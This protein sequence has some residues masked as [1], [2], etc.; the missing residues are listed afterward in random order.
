M[1]ILV[2]AGSEKKLDSEECFNENM[3]RLGGCLTWPWSSW[4]ICTTVT[5]GWI[6][7]RWRRSCALAYTCSNLTCTR[8]SD[9]R[10][11]LLKLY[12]QWISGQNV[13]WI[14]TFVHAFGFEIFKAAEILKSWAS[15][16]RK[17]F[18][19][20]VLS[21]QNGNRSEGLNLQENCIYWIRCLVSNDIKRIYQHTHKQMPAYIS[22]RSDV[23]IV[24]T[25][26]VPWL[27]YTPQRGRGPA[28][29]RCHY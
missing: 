22:G 19:G 24:D 26:F 10:M 15:M 16:T 9:C 25:G 2:Q 29:D 11:S 4:R 28:S 3:Y 14:G 23:A 27:T 8:D 7:F 6:W 21:Y 18:E 13:H 20:T 12:F 17:R 1:C 5:N